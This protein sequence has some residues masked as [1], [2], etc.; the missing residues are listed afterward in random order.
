[1]SRAFV[2]DD[3]DDD[4][5]VVPARAPLPD[6]VPNRVTPDGLAAL[7]DER[8]ALEVDLE[9]ARREADPRAEAAAAGRLDAV[10]ARLASARVVEVPEVPEVADVGVVVALQRAD[11]ARVRFRIVGVDEA[12][13]AADRVAFTAPVAAAAI[14]KRVGERLTAHVGERDVGF[15]VVGLER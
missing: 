15:E 9:R 6:G 3:A 4:P 10:R 12:D 8:A 13:P 2:K 11:G 1:M 14:G 5:V 7:E